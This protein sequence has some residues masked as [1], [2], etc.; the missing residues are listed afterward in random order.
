MWYNAYQVGTLQLDKSRHQR[1]PCLPKSRGNQIRPES[2]ELADL[3]AWGVF[4]LPVVGK[5]EENLGTG[6]CQPLGH[7][8]FFHF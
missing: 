1:T 2:C 5:E 7:V 8:L 3:S 6:A 4:S